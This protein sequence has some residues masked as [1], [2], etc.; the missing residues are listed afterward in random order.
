VEDLHYHPADLYRALMPYTD[1][2]QFAVDEPVF[3]VLRQGMADD[4]F[5]ASEA[6]PAVDTPAHALL[7]LPDA[8][9][10]RRVAGVFGNRL[11]TERPDRAHAVLTARPGGYIVSVRAPIER[12]AGADALCRQ[13]ESGG[14]RAGAAGI[15]HLPAT[16]LDRFAQ[17]FAV[18]YAV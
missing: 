10:S 14:G 17:A 3:E 18:A 4:L 1:P 16:D 13:F 12:P 6:Q 15:N 9:W 8:A 2:L 5:L 7:I 11:A